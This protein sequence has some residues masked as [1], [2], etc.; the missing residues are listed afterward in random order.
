M[1]LRQR[2]GQASLRAQG[3]YFQRSGTV[4]STNSSPARACDANLGVL[5]LA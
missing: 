1:Y 5:V 2:V 3:V 4:S